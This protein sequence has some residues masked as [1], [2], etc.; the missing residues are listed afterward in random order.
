MLISNLNKV[1]TGTKYSCLYTYQRKISE[2]FENYRFIN[3]SF[4]N[5]FF[6]S[7]L[8]YD[9]SFV[10]NYP[11]TRKVKILVRQGV[12]VI[13]TKIALKFDTISFYEISKFISY[14]II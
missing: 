12:N 13:F 7:Q 5:Y 1:T 6:E 11:I 14:V 8:F 3:L 2:N 10:Y 9:S 4:N